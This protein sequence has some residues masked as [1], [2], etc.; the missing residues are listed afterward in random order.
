MMPNDSSASHGLYL[1]CQMTPPRRMAY[2]YNELESYLYGAHNRE[3]LQTGSWG[4]R[5]RQLGHTL[6]LSDWTQV[7]SGV[8]V[9]YH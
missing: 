1:S 4:I 3:K 9:L 5:D 8:I 7:S 2:I 6:T